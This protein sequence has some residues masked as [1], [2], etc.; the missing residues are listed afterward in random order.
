MDVPIDLPAG[1]SA[2]PPRESD[3]AAM[4]AVI[5]AYEERFLG[6]VMIELEDLE[7]DWQRPSFDPDRDAVLVLD[8]DEV[9]ACGEVHQARRVTASVRPD[10]AGRGIGAALVDWSVRLVAQRGGSK[11]GQTVPD[12]DAAAAQLFRSRGWA[13]LWTSW[14]LELPPGEAIAP[15]P[16]PGGYRLRT[17]RPGQDEQAAYQ[18]VEDAFGEWPEREPTTYGDWAATVVGRPGF[19]PWQLLLAVTGEGEAEQ[20]VGACHL[21]VSGGAGWVNQV[22][23]SRA[24]RGRGIA[25][26]LLAAAFAAARERGADKAELSTDSRTGALSLYERLGM[27]VKSSFTQWAGDPTESQESSSSTTDTTTP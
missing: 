25:Q 12:A 7:A 13:P 3:L 5:A 26:A 9:V 19:E 1:L 22:A 23:V 17:L 16:L 6:E 4:H 2:R 10:A 27:R 20:V 18:V 11:V 8:G 14:V 24:H 21:I 15:R